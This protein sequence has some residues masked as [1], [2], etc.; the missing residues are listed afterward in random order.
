MLFEAHALILAA[1]LLLV[2][3][4]VPELNVE[5]SCRAAM[6]AN[7]GSGNRNENAC[8]QDE[9]AAKTALQK[10]WSQFSADQKTHC[11]R[12]L[13]AGGSP[14][15]VELLTCAEMGKAAK[16]LNAQ[17]N[18]HAQTGAAGETT[19]SGAAGTFNSPK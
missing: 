4:K 8:M 17:K 12:L 7:I 5:P 13:N 1:Q 9:K 16:E 14:S 15:Y 19:G 10:E 2:A 6:Q 18:T 3:D 11:I